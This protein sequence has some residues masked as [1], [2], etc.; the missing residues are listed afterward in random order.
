MKCIAFVLPQ[1]HQISENDTWWGE[2]FT[3]WT[4]VRKAAALYPEHDQ[5]K[6]P[7]NDFYYDLTDPDVK[8]WQAEIA[9]AHGI[10]GFC[11]YHYW[12][13]GRR[14]LEQPVQQILAS[15]EPDFP[16]CLSWAN[17]PWTRKWDGT[18]DD[19]LMPQEYGD[20]SEWQKHFFTLLEAFHDE[21]YIRVDDKPIFII[22]RPSSIPRCNDMLQY[23]RDLA[24]ENGL[25]G[26]HIIRTL[27][28][29]P[30][31]E[32]HGFDASLEFEPHYTFAHGGLQHLWSSKQI[33]DKQ[34][35]VID[36]DQVWESIL[37]RSPHRN[38]ELIYPGA[39][40]NWDNTP[41][42]GAAGQSTLGANPHKFGIYLARQIE[43]AKTM[44]RSDFIYI[45]AW[46]EWAEGAYLEPDAHHQYQYL[47]A[48]KEALQYQHEEDP[49]TP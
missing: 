13:N 18:E 1:F 10:Y 33:N 43:R 37:E 47:Q 24:L 15:K 5:P 34:H 29:F 17:E 26:L 28:G 41:R 21:R 3:E 45:N 35:I 19:V 25:K 44:F 42:I 20:E 12:F 39:F 36:Y 49:S 31:D 48:I 14:L 30:L 9:K 6:K 38:G 40:V 11:Y 22:Y 8:K 23:W 32:Q 2:G 27:G 4:N 7:L 46:N 16:F